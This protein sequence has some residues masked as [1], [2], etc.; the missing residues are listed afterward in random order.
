MKSV[1]T[2]LLA[3]LLAALMLLPLAACGENQENT[4][5]QGNTGTGAANTTPESEGVETKAPPTVEKNNYKGDEFIVLY[6]SDIFRNGYYL[7]E[8]EDRTPGNELED[9]IYARTLAVED[10]LGVDVI[11]QDGG[12]FTEYLS[13]ATTSISSGD[14]NYQLILTHVYYG[15]SNFITENYARPFNDFDSLNLNAYYWQTELMEDL[16]INDRMYLG[17]NDF[18]LSNCYV[19]G[20]NKEMVAEY[21]NTVGDLYQ[22]VLDKEWTLDKFMEYSALVSKDNGDGKW[23]VQDTYGFAGLAW[24]PLISFQTAADIPIIKTNEAGEL[25]VS[26]LVDN[27]EKIVNLDQKLYDFANATYTYMWSPGASYSGPTESLDISTGRV[28]FQTMNNF[29][30]VTTKENDVKIGVLPYPLWD[31]K[32]TEYKTL[33]WNGLMVIPTSV[34]DLKMVGD[35]IEMLAYYSDDVTTAFYETLLGAKVADAPQDVQMLDIIWSSQVSDKGL[36]FSSVTAQ[37]DGI[38][39]AIPQHISAGKPAY[40][41][42]VRSLIPP[43]ERALK[44]LYEKDAE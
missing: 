4:E 5:T 17:Y 8:E 18:C 38:L 3:L 39:Y 33:N 41:T 13:T 23:D 43:T 20:F 10:Y 42:H 29:S 24:V 40:A 19:I 12:T 35:V 2:K 31:K 6:C 22:Q 36:V 9:K 28:M 15:V 32:Q 7:V 1:T 27:A 26:P 25:Y 16:A 30:L 37:M 44:K 14:D 34:Q 21:K 11:G